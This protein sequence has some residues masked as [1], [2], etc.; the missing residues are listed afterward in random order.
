VDA[1][2]K[3]D[4]SD[5]SRIDF[6]EVV[7]GSRTPHFS[8]SREFSHSLGQYLA[9][10]TFANFDHDSADGKA[11]SRHAVDHGAAN[12]DSYT[13]TRALQ[14]ILTLDQLAFFT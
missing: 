8:C 5:R 4:A 11:S 10:Q 3:S 13:M 12:A 6:F 9:N 7:K 14:V 1:S 2:S